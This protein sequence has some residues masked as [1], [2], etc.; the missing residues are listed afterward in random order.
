MKLSCEK[1]AVTSVIQKYK[2]NFKS[3]IFLGKIWLFCK[4]KK[5]WK[6]SMECNLGKLPNSNNMLKNLNLF[7]TSVCFSVGAY[8]SVGTYNNHTPSPSPI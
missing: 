2:D 1:N 3:I 8:N 7:D 6:L 4:K 5:L